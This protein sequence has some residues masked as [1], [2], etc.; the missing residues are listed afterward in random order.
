M[1][2]EWGVTESG[3][4]CPTYE[5]ILDD[6]IKRAKSLFGEDISTSELTLLGKFLRIEAKSD[7]RIYETAEG[8][9]YSATPATATGV[10][11]ERM[12][13]FIG[14]NKNTAV[15]AVHVVRIYGVQ[16]YTV[17]AG[18]TLV[19][20]SAGVIFYPVVDATIGSEETT[21]DG[22]VSYYADV[23][24]QCAV[25]GTEGN[26]SGINSTVNVVNE[27]TGVSYLYQLTEG[28]DTETDAEYR[29]RYEQIVQGLGTNTAAAIIAEVLKIDGAYACIV[30]NNSEDS[31]IAISPKLTIAKDTYAVIVHADS[32]LSGEIAQAIFKK[33]P[34]GIRQSG[35]ETVEVEDNAGEMHKVRFTYV[36]EKRIDVVI[37]CTVSDEFESGG[38]DEIRENIKTYMNS[39]AIGKTLI[40]SKLYERI[41]TVKGVED[42]LE[43]TINGGRE[44][45]SVSSIEIIKCGTVTVTTTEV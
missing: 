14:E 20:N 6:K 12:G 25:A 27:I 32:S 24:V 23:I 10:S 43:L 44:N 3:F 41:H 16:G 36:D 35:V 40:Y 15:C 13:A 8:V 42:V 22:G 1:A 7:Q 34:F 18:T 9:Y 11:L 17:K 5:E 2:N 19:R 26:T 30:K 45:I 21:Q 37:K 31:D 4:Y 33:M 28:R 38:V 29:A 39:L